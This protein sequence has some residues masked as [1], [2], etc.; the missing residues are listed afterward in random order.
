MTQIPAV[1]EHG[2]LFRK[3]PCRPE[4]PLTFKV[5]ADSGLARIRGEIRIMPEKWVGLSA[6]ARMEMAPPWEVK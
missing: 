4:R 6:A 5:D 2:I 1:K 3:L